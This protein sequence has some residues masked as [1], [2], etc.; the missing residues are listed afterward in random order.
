MFVLVALVGGVVALGSYVASGPR[1]R[2]ITAALANDPDVEV[3]PTRIGTFALRTRPHLRAARFAESGKGP[4]PWRIRTRAPLLSARSTLVFLRRGL[5]PMLRH[6]DGATVVETSWDEL[7]SVVI[8]RGSSP[9]IVRGW[10]QSLT[11]RSHVVQLFADPEIQALLLS[12]QGDVEVEMIG[13][14]VDAAQIKKKLLDAV[15]VVEALEQVVD[16]PAIAMLS[17]RIDEG[18][19]GASSG[20]PFVIPLGERR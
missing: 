20:T 9:D 4:H 18:G 8:I 2:T 14:S 19:V 13:P 15:A 3:E 7:E 11:V 5:V 10:L 17:H 6:T 1:M 12:P 16:A